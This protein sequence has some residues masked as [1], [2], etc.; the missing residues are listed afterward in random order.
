MLNEKVPYLVNLFSGTEIMV[1]E[2]IRNV[3]C[4]FSVV[5]FLFPNGGVYYSFST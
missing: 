2:L 4:V 3:V 5:V 1:S